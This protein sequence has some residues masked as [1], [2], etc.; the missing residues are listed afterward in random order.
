MKKAMAMS[1]EADHEHNGEDNDGDN[2]VDVAMADNKNKKD[3]LESQ[4][5]DAGLGA[6]ELDLIQQIKAAKGITVTLNAS[7]LAGL[8]KEEKIVKFRSVQNEYRE[9]KRK[10]IV[11]IKLDKERRRRDGVKKAQDAQKT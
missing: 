7:D 10:N 11:K 9:E 5:K 1:M 6:D 4:L 2:G 8:S 3:D